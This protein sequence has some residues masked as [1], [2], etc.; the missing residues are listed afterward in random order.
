MGSRGL[1]AAL[2]SGARELRSSLAAR[3]LGPALLSSAVVLTL[4]ATDA[5]RLV[6]ARTWD[7]LSVVAPPRPAAPGVV[8]VA[9]DEPSF[10]ELGRQ[11]PWPRSLH[12]KLV[13]SLRAAGAKVIGLDILFAEPSSPDEDAALARA[14][15]P[16][17]VLAADEETLTL[18][19][20]TQVSRVGPLPALT[21]SGARSGLTSLVLD[22]DGALRR[23]PVSPDSFAA[24]V[25]AA[26]GHPAGEVPEGA[27]IQFFGDPRTYPTIS[28][29]QALDPLRYL[30]KGR[31]AGQ[32]VLVGL[33][34][35]NAPDVATGGSDAFVTPYTLTSGRLTAGVEVHGT[36]IDNLR[37]QFWAVPLG[38]AAVAGIVLLAALAAGL[39]AGRQ[40]SWRTGI[41]AAGSIV[42]LVAASWM[43]LRY[44]RVFVSPALP[45]AAALGVFG[46]RFGLDY[47]LERQQRRAVSEAFS[48]Y[49]A[50]ELVE[51]LARDPSALRLGGELRRLT[52][53]FCDVRGFTS[54]SEKLKDQPQRLTS[55]VN[56]LLDALTA[57]VLAEKGTIDKY[58][59]DCVMAFWNAPL[60]HP[61]HAAAAVRAALAMSGAVERVNEELAASWDGPAPKLA[62]GVGINTGECV[63]GNMGSR[64]R[65]DYSVLGDPVNLASRLESLT[66]DLGVKLIL[67]PGT[68]AAVKDRYVLVELDRIAVRGRSE[69]TAVHT[70]LADAAHAGDP[71][72][73]AL[74]DT[75][76]RM[77]AAMRDGPE[78][79]GEARMLIHEC[80]RLAPQLTSHY[81][82]L[83]DRLDALA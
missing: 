53:L 22:G 45:S 18:E 58:M 19:Q 61:D 28:Y 82:R 16:D 8:V 11:W 3:I 74:L 12:A 78:R 47:A 13:E 33:S 64:W 26:A 50:P 30:P 36:I 21:A 83:L 48:R 49:V 34:L 69:A 35:K 51:Q 46:I 10:A 66:K 24:R 80:K 32:T 76:S 73:I 23:M 52:I 42:L 72:V 17:V 75:Q 56:R 31:L 25:L 20:G 15:G 65:Y 62:V 2:A 39:A 63:V 29:Y 43:L 67:G 27:L 44:G 55:V 68:A 70:V 77:L 7:L 6:E 4:G 38:R 71:Q 40:T 5:Y 79:A 81:D 60:P 9:V 1:L 14:M 57:E 59:G 41:A 54:L 37:E